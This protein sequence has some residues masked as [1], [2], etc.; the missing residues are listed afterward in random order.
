MNVFIYSIH[1]HIYIYTCKYIYIYT[2]CLYKIHIQ[3]THLLILPED[4]RGARWEESLLFSCQAPFQGKSRS[5]SGPHAGCAELRLRRKEFLCNTIY[6][7]LFVHVYNM[8]M[9]I[10]K[11]YYDVLFISICNIVSYRIKK[12]FSVLS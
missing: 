5:I 9:C 3:H 12:V 1:M 11:C 8:S 10:S 4:R 6:K 2:D 7:Q